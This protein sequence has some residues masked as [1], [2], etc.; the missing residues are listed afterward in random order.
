MNYRQ[1]TEIS[2]FS[3]RTQRRWSSAK[4]TAWSLAIFFVAVLAYI[5]FSLLDGGTTRPLWFRVSTYILLSLAALG[6]TLLYGRNSR[7]TSIP[8]GRFVWGLLWW[9]AASGTV[10]QVLMLF[11]EQVWGLRP[12]ISPADPFFVGFYI[13]HLWGLGLLISRQKLTLNW[14]Q[15]AIVCLVAAFA[16]VVA[17]KL[18]DGVTGVVTIPQS[19]H[20]WGIA[21]IKTFQHLADGFSLFYVLADVVL[22]IMATILS[23][24]FW[25]GRLASAWQIMAQGLVCIYLADIWFA[26][27][28]KTASYRSGDLME[29]LWLAGLLQLAIAAALEWENGQRLQRLIQR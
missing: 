17:I 11:W 9:G 7:S 23:L 25:G 13:F 21:F 22:V 12:D 2:L 1:S 29:L 5:L 28:A 15:A 20:P 6:S 27:L 3:I 4:V 16:T 18:L 19:A 24:S 10:A 26:Y 8:S 14:R